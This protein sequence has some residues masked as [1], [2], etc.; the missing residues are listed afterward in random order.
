MDCPEHP[1]IRCVL[2]SGD[3][4]DVLVVEDA[5]GA[6]RA[7]QSYTYVSEELFTEICLKRDHE[8]RAH[9]EI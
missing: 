2:A 5:Q 9:M 8:H 3:A 7:I 6:K 1:E 4:R